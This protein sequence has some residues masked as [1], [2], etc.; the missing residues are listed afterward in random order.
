MATRS[1]RRCASEKRLAIVLAGSALLAGIVLHLSNPPA[2]AQQAAPQRTASSQPSAQ[3]TIATLDRMAA[4]GKS[5]R[6]L[7]QYV[8]ETHGCNNCHTVGQNGKLGFTKKGDQ[9]GQGFEGCISLLT[10]MTV[11]AQVREDKRSP[12]QRDKAARFEEFGCAFCHKVVPGELGL[13]EVGSKLA[14]LHLG[15]VDIQKVVAS[16]TAEKR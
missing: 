2:A 12:V 16:S 14:H 4:E 6:N 1:Q 8:F 13:T 3:T 5:P 11:I 10:A 15:C 7:A 9:A